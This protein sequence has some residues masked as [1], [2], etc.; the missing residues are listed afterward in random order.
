[1]TRSVIR[2]AFFLLVLI[3]PAAAQENH[4]NHGELEWR[5]IETPHFFIHYHEGAERT[6]NVIAKVA[7]DIYGPVTTLYQHEP[8]HKVSFIIKD[9]DD[10]SNGAAYFYDNK[11]EIWAPSLDFN[12]RGTHNWLRNVIAHEFTHI[13]QIQTSMKF[14]RRFPA[15]YLQWLN[16]EEERRQD[17]LYGYPNTVVSYPVSG[18]IV[19][20]WFAEGVAQ[21]NRPELRYDFWDTHRD[22]ILRSYVLDS[23]MLSW[24]E[25][26][27]FGKT[28]LGNESSYNAG[29]ALTRYIS[30]KY[31]QDAIPRIA[32]GISRLNS[33]M[34][35]QSIQQTLGI[36]GDALYQEWKESITKRYVEQTAG[37]RSALVEGKQSILKGEDS[38]E[39]STGFGNLNPS[40][41][42]VGKKFVYTSNK[43]ADYFGLSSVYLGDMETGKEKLLTAGVRSQLSWSPDGSR[44]YYTK[45]TH[46]NPH[47][48]ELSDIYYYDLNEE[49]EERLTF[50]QR[51]ISTSVSP[52]GKRFAITWQKDGTVNIAVVDSAGKDF[53]QLT[54][55]RNG[56]QTYHPKWS[57]DGKWII[58]AYSVK[59]GQDIARVSADSGAVEFLLT[60]DHDDRDPVYTPDGNG[61]IYSSDQ[62]GIFNLYRYSFFD[63][64]SSLLSNVIGG[65]FT[66]TIHS[67]GS[68][69]YS[70]Y[71][72]SGYKLMLFDQAWPVDNEKAVYGYTRPAPKTDIDPWLPMNK[73]DFASLRSYNDN[74]LKPLESRPYKNTYTS[75]AIVPFLRID[76][77]N[78]KS[79]GLDFLKPGFYFMSSDVVDK[80]NMFG[81][82][83]VNHILERDLFLIFEYRDRLLGL[84]QLGLHPTLSFE[85][86]NVTRK[87]TGERITIVEKFLETTADIT[88]SL[89]EVDLFMKQHL[90]GPFDL[91]T[92]GLTY[93][94]YSSELGAFEIAD[95]ISAPILVPSSSDTYFKGKNL[96]LSYAFDGILPSRTMEINPV[97]RSFSLR[98]DNEAAD[99]VAEDSTG[100][101]EFEA[102]ETGIK[103]KLIPYTVRRAEL[104]YTEHLPLP[105]G[106]HT[107]SF[108]LR[109][110]TVFGPELPDFFDFYAGG[111][112]GMKGYPFYS[113]SGNE[114]ASLNVAYRFPIWEDMDIRLWQLSLS[115]LYGEFHADIGNA[116]SGDPDI[117][118]FKKDVG[119]ELRVDAFSWYAFPTRIFLNGTYGLDSFTYDR[120]NV[121]AQYGKE[122]RFYFGVLFGFDFSND[123]K[124]LARHF[125][126]L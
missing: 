105:Y 11:I 41:A 122:W 20:S 98:L 126:G 54:A 1:M 89:F 73:F 101:S 52:D 66:P 4:Y 78:T 8:E 68:I 2:S 46:D 79:S 25:M 16:Y 84:H 95:G 48:S 26:S 18:F 15:F 34:I 49:E 55:F 83:A 43:T 102:T 50:G 17:V 64:S 113:I 47:G 10:Y 59:D 5:T 80:M 108:T 71:T 31:G 33:I 67:D 110:G 65:A 51:A 125:D 24:S 96:S 103:L 88:Y 104:R 28:S 85:V 62:S 91:L 21:Y 87:R 40:F 69:I 111:L 121:K 119:F 92:L 38:L 6:A 3:L 44:I 70:A 7:E 42:P 81:G 100:A 19:P 93:S 107:L 27:V 29:F 36:T 13:I 112:V 61:F 72:S 116:W 57:P 117:K 106:K 82:A 32:K 118:D 90:L 12:L 75:L 123:M 22:M 120:R 23:N 86:Y 115:R 56:E 14:G 35:D 97:G 39:T 30:E 58:F 9:Y 37:I 99:F 124:R 45:I 77:Y 109:A 60:G 53:R 114:V 94:Q 63:G 76:N 74:D